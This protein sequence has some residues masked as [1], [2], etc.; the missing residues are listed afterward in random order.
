MI[1]LSW[2][3]Q[4]IFIAAGIILI[5]LAVLSFRI[6]EN[7]EDKWINLAIV[8][9]GI[10]VGL[11]LGMYISPYGTGERQ[12]FAEYATAV[13]AFLSGYL[14]AK[15]DGLITKLFSPEQ[16]LRP[17]AGFRLV[18]GFSSLIVT[19]LITYVVRAYA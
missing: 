17:V 2:K 9:L 10:S 19:M 3:Q 14:L 18:S 15:I 12:N 1:A 11:L 4:G 13:S 16:I 7:E 5:T 8:V 6:K